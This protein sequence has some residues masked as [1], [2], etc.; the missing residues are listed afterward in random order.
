MRRLL[1]GALLVVAA[2]AALGQAAEPAAPPQG[3]QTQGGEGPLGLFPQ[4]AALTPEQ[5]SALTD[6]LAV[7]MSALRGLP[8]FAP[9]NKQMHTQAELR[10]L[11]LAKLDKDWP[12]EQVA[13]WSEAYQALGLLPAGVDLRAVLAAVMGEQVAGAYDPDTKSMLLV[14]GVPAALVA[15]VLMHELTHA[16]QDAH[17]HLQSLP[18]EQHDNDDLALAVEALIEGDATAVMFD[19]VAGRDTST[20]TDLDGLLRSGPQLLGSPQLALAPRAVRELLTFP[21]VTGLRLVNELRRRGGWERVNAAYQDFPL[22]TEQV[23]HPEKF[24]AGEDR[25]QQVLLPEALGRAVTGDLIQENVLGEFGLRLLLEEYTTSEEAFRA[26]QGWGGDR[27]RVWRRESR[28]AGRS[29]LVL[30]VTTWDSAADAQEFFAAYGRLVGNKYQKAEEEPTGD[31]TRRLW[32]TERGEVEVVSRG[33]DVLVLE[34]FRAEEREALWQALSGYRKEAF[35]W[36]PPEPAA[37]PAG[38]SPAEK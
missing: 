24:L 35:R 13:R 17:F 31:A 23:L 11:F 1:L 34:G 26:A 6:R 16:A 8:L 37:V 32:R 38:S 7:R 5:L 33:S 15:P 18:W 19:F 12:P 4:G 36:Q 25:P 29:W 28:Q 27:F 30:L 2:S 9:V 3:A 22:S 21:Y 10:Q 14:E 20:I